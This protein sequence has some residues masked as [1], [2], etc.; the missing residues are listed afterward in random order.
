[1]MYCNQHSQTH[2]KNTPTANHIADQRANHPTSQPI[3]S[4][5][6]SFSQPHDQPTCQPN[7]PGCL[8]W[9]ARWLPDCLNIATSAPA[10]VSTCSRMRQTD[11]E[12]CLPE[13]HHSMKAAASPL[14]RQGSTSRMMAVMRSRCCCLS[15]TQNRT[16]TSTSTHTVQ[17][18][19]PHTINIYYHTIKYQVLTHY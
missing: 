2:N 4:T 3:K 12:R 7:N 11:T 18:T 9:L 1:M 17:Q 13:R 6:Q 8:K 14:A 5:I 19:T 10:A 15:S 16:G